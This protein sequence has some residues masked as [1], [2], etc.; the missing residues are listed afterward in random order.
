VAV[1]LPWN[2]DAATACDAFGTA[3]PVVVAGGSVRVDAS[4]TPVFI[5]SPVPAR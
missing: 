5:E 2:P 1:V 3:A 4:V